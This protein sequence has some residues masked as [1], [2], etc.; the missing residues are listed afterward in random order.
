MFALCSNID[1]LAIT[2]S[3]KAKGPPKQ[4]ALRK[5]GYGAS[6]QLSDG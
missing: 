3:P 4:A 1:S 6:N 5:G 2:L